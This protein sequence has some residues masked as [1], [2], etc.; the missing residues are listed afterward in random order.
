MEFDPQTLHHKTLYKL[1]TGT[2]IPRPIAWVSTL[3]ANDQP[4]LAPFSYFNAVCAKPPT[5]LF[6]TSIRGTDGKPKD[7]YFNVKN[8]RE[9]V[10]NIVTEETAEAMNISSTEFPPDVNEFEAANLTPA[11]SQTVKPPRVLESPVSFECRLKQIIDISDQPGGGSIIIGT[12]V[13]IHIADEVM[14]GGDKIDPLLLKP[15][16]RL[17]G[18][19]YSRVSDLFELVRPSS[20]VK[21]E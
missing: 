10:V 7:T 12:V 5:L 2:I 15:V 1:I 16:G 9:F 4:N 13:H 21:P 20:Q 17:A 14:F 8:T 11:P 6:S 18:Y 19:Q 3:N